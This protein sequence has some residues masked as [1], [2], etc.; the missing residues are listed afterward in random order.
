MSAS[1]A[2][3]LHVALHVYLSVLSYSQGWKRVCFPKQLQ[4]PSYTATG[5]CTFGL[6]AAEVNAIQ[7]C[8]NFIVCS[9]QV[10]LLVL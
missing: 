8:T 6:T 9:T 3:G 5:V 10:D 2:K 1:A 4:M 7:V